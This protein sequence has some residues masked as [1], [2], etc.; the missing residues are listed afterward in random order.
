[1]EGEPK[2]TYRIKDL[3]AEDRPRERLAQLGVGALTKAE[4]LAILLRTGVPGESAIHLAERLMQTF[5]G[6]KG[7]HRASFEELCRVRGLGVAKASQLKAALELGQRLKQEE[8]GER[9][10]INSPQDAADL[11]MHAMSALQQEELWVLALDTRNHVLHT[12]KLYTGSLNHSSVRIAEIFEVGIR[13][14]AAA[15]IVVHNHPS[16]DPS[17]SPEDI[18]LTRALLESGKLLDIKVLD[19][20]IIGRDVFVSMKQ[21]KLGFD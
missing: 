16:G 10:T 14:K 12:E 5:G 15:L 8:A 7:L 9:S 11:V 18:Q 13:H 20:L 17:P 19:H 2:T 21:R 3:S 1:M 6:L 4:L